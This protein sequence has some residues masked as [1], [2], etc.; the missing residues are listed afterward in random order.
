M[1]K[2]KKVK[3]SEW[4]EGLLWAE[5]VLAY[6]YDVSKKMFVVDTDGMDGYEIL[7]KE[8]ERDDF[9]VVKR[10]SREYGEGVIDY[11]E[12]KEYLAVSK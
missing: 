9:R 12:Y 10:V 4:M 5:D 1:F 11:I 7:W 3:L 2:K 8:R 6:Y